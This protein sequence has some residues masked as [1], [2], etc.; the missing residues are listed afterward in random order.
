[1]PSF[2]SCCIAI[3][4]LPCIVLKIAVNQ[5]KGKE[6]GVIVENDPRLIG[7]IK[8]MIVKVN[9]YELGIGCRSTLIKWGGQT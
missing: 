1:M 4:L 5:V 3:N 9:E 8:F 2:L 6:I 7:M